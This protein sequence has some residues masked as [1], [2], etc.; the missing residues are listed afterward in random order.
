MKGKRKKRRELE[1]GRWREL[2][3]KKKEDRRIRRQ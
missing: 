1:R 3:G 2:E